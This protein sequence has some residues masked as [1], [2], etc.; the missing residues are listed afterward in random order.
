MAG[1]QKLFHEALKRGSALAWSGRWAESAAEYRLALAQFPDDLSARSY[2]AM[3]LYKSGQLEEAL[4]LYEGLWR[5]QPT[6]LATLRRVAELQEALG[7]WESAAGSFRMLAEMYTSRGAGTDALHAWRKVVELKPGDPTL[8][9]M[10][11]EAAVR[12]GAVGE[13][14]PAYLGFA[15]DL[16]VS[17]RFQEATAAAETAQKL[18]PEN[19]SVPT[20]VLAL[21]RAL[22]CT[23]RAAAVGEQL[24]REELAR[25][26]SP[27]PPSATPEES[28]ARGQP[29]PDH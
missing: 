5:A 26:I 6:N 23:W 27:V 29:C 7:R 9:R 18:D 11:V 22:E 13:V 21:R 15:R 19:P 1:D 12:A 3:S 20:L 17:G 4:E 8:W 25:L 16:A 10:L 14:M 28:E 2:L 24:S